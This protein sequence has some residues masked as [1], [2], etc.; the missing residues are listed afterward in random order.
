M[1]V[2]V[3]K[4]SIIILSGYISCLDIE[5]ECVNF[6]RTTCTRRLYT[7]LYC[8]YDIRIRIIPRLYNIVTNMREYFKILCIKFEGG[9]L[10]YSLPRSPNTHKTFFFLSLFFLIPFFFSFIVWNMHLMNLLEGIPTNLFLF[11]LEQHQ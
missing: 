1:R 5:I 11:Y 7:V 6:L 4:L 9:L 8:S 10:V 2:D 3:K